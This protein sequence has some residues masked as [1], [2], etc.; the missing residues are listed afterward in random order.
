M[1]DRP[2]G[3]WRGQAGPPSAP[4]IGRLGHPGPHDVPTL[5]LPFFRRSAE[6]WGKHSS[7]MHRCSSGRQRTSGRKRVS[8]RKQH[9]TPSAVANLFDKKELF[10]RSAA[11]ALRVPSHITERNQPPAPRPTAALL[12]RH[13][14]WALILGPFL[15]LRSPFQVIHSSVLVVDRARQYWRSGVGWSPQS[16]VLRPACHAGAH[17]RVGIA[18][19]HIQS[20]AIDRSLGA[21]SPARYRALRIRFD[22]PQPTAITAELVLSPRC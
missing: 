4:S 7:Q 14:N 15:H 21:L 11:G 19:P 20:R 9:R 1:T 8:E 12:S 10:E 2:W 3:A 16:F 22:P 18:R 17:V 6:A 13:R 5:Q